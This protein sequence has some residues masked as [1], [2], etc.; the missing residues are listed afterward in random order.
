MSKGFA[1]K[2]FAL[3]NLA[4]QFVLHVFR[5]LFFW[6]KSGLVQFENNYRSDGFLPL[7]AQDQSTL[8]SF[9]ACLNCRLCDSAC[10]AIFKHPRE[11][12]LGPSFVLT[13]YSRSFHDLWATRLD[14]SL[15]QDC[16]ACMNVCP[17]GI[18]VKGAISFIQKKVAEQI[19][20][21][22]GT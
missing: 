8:F 5:K 12:F 6:K 17:N 15:C 14:L 22:A 10:P 21:A 4:F 7:T 19:K 2:T 11:R 9:S 1:K 18:D 20:F 3:L 13:T 16:E